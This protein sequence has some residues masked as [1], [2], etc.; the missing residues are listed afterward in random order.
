MLIPVIL[1]NK[2]TKTRMKASIS[3]GSEETIKRLGYKIEYIQ[4][5]VKATADN[6]KISF[7]EELN[8]NSQSSF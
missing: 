5:P 2:K 1:I 4:Q 3:E 8:D 7:L 6:S